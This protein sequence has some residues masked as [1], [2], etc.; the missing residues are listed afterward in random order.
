MQSVENNAFNNT[1]YV[2]WYGVIRPIKEMFIYLFKAE[3][4]RQKNSDK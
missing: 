3:R 1:Y 4:I 2:P